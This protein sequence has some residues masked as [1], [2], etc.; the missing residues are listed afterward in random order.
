MKYNEAD[1][2]RDPEGKYTDKAT[3]A[4]GPHTGTATMPYSDEAE[5]WFEKADWD[6]LDEY[7]QQT[8][9]VNWDRVRRGLHAKETLDLAE[10]DLKEAG[11]EPMES[12]P[13]AAHSRF[14][15]SFATPD[16][17][18][19]PYV[20]LSTSVNNPDEPQMI[21]LDAPMGVVPKGTNA[22]QSTAWMVE[23]LNDYDRDTI[24]GELDGI[25]GMDEVEEDAEEDADEETINRRRLGL[26]RDRI[27][28]PVIAEKREE[29]GIAYG[30]RTVD[31]HAI[32]GAADP[33]GRGEMEPFTQHTSEGADR[34][35]ARDIGTVHEHWDEFY[36]GYPKPDRPP[37]VEEVKAAGGADGNIEHLMYAAPC[38]MM[39]RD[40]EKIEP[41]LAQAVSRDLRDPEYA[42]K[43]G[44]DRVS[45][46]ARNG[47]LNLTQ[48][49]VRTGMLNPSDLKAVW[50]RW[51][52][53]PW[54]QNVRMAVVEQVRAHRR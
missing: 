13:E 10:N 19:I 27:C 18:S 50:D 46:L 44:H 20:T 45:M 48:N 23:R 38:D 42:R 29:T 35:L 36:P 26:M 37:T 25:Q 49:A 7:I 4:T 54:S 21:L 53:S 30:W 22:A 31:G 40:R 1:H 39:R 6:D 52:D 34:N 32:P 41:P 2:P 24:I 8:G 15:S 12:Y 11:Y 43:M 14:V 3:G 33:F 51:R 47:D 16:G 5:E 28:R 17:S 9:D